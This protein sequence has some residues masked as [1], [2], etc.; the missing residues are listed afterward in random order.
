MPRHAL[1]L[2]AGSIRALLAFGVLAAL[3][4]VVWTFGRENEEIRKRQSITFFYLQSL[5][6]LITASFFASHGSTIGP[7]ISIGSPL[8]LPRGSVRFLLIVGYLGLAYFTYHTQPPFEF[9]ETQPVLILLLVLLSGFF[10]GHLLSGLIRSLAGGI[11]PY[12][13]QDIQAWVALIAVGV[14]M[15]VALIHVINLSLPA[16]MELEGTWVQAILAGT[17]GFYFGAR[18]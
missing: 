7:H 8:G 5:M 11:T 18:S 15:L 9:P 6:L 13:F 16:G 12:W 4:V 17:V 14:L 1:G 10:L 3:W 2:P